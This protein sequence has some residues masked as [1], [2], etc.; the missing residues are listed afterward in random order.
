MRVIDKALFE[1][2]NVEGQAPKLTVVSDPSNQRQRIIEGD[3]Q[4]TVVRHRHLYLKKDATPAESLILPPP[5]PLTRDERA[6]I[7]PLAHMCGSGG[8]GA[9]LTQAA[10]KVSSRA[11]AGTFAGYYLATPKRCQVPDCGAMQTVQLAHLVPPE[12]KNFIISEMTY[13]NQEDDVFVT[14]LCGEHHNDSPSAPA[15]IDVSNFGKGTVWRVPV[16][17]GTN[18]QVKKAHE[19]KTITLKPKDIEGT[20]YRQPVPDAG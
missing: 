9:A 20:D 5:K 14:L 15:T 6:T 16:F 17:F 10:R 19:K 4:V 13:P 3:T 8:L 1:M 7:G 12:K 11:L 2:N 18:E